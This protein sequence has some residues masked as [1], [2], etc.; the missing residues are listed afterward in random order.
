M[1]ARKGFTL[2]ELL[3][4]IAIIAILAAILFP[5]FAQA[6]AKARQTTCL[7]NI[8]QITLATLM[9]ADDYDG[10]DPFVVTVAPHPRCCM[11]SYYPSMMINFWSSAN[12]GDDTW[13]WFTDMRAAFRPYTKNDQLFH[14]PADSGNAWPSRQ[15]LIDAGVNPDDPNDWVHSYLCYFESSGRG[16]DTSRLPWDVFAGKKGA[17]IGSTYCTVDLNNH[18]VNGPWTWDNLWGG[19]WNNGHKVD[20]SGPASVPFI[21]CDHGH[22]AVFRANGSQDYD[23]SSTNFGYFDGHVKYAKGWIGC[24]KWD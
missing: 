16:S 13:G 12:G 23:A 20:A 1:Q 22:D 14:C 10:F 17:D 3:V 2:I 6:R 7:S 19:S 11:N 4:V 15:N 24:F 8:K 5:V 18:S 9:Y 21:W